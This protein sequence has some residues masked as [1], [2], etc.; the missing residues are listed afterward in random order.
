VSHREVRLQD[1]A[2]GIRSG[3]R[4]GR[5]T[6]VSDIVMVVVVVVTVGWLLTRGGRPTGTSG[7]TPPGVT[8]GGSATWSSTRTPVPADPDLDRQGLGDD[9]GAGGFDDDW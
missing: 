6:T 1:R 4:T 9:T 8:L 7:A 5:G 3:T 2:P